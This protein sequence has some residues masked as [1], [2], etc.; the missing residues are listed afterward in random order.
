MRAVALAGAGV[1]AVDLHRRAG[2]RFSWGLGSGGTGLKKL[3]ET[4][5]PLAE[6][7]RGVELLGVIVA[8][9]GPVWR[10]PGKKPKW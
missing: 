10:A 5:K 6:A 9:S 3:I 2:V 4:A 8:P 7:A 1:L